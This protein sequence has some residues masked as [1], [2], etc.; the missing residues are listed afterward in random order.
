[1]RCGCVGARSPE[2]VSGQP[3]VIGEGS[4][5]VAVAHQARLLIDPPANFARPV[6]AE[7]L[8]GQPDLIGQR[9]PLLDNP[10]GDS[11]RAHTPMPQPVF[12]TTP[13]PGTPSVYRS[14]DSSPMSGAMAI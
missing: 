3:N 1:M 2:A 13:G 10:H 8:V 4:S 9:R 12:A 14:R 6:R 7:Q 11:I 5:K